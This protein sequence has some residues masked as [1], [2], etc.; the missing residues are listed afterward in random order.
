[1][2]KTHG[3]GISLRSLDVNGWIDPEDEEMMNHEVF[4]RQTLLLRDNFKCGVKVLDEEKKMLMIIDSSTTTWNRRVI[5]DSRKF[6]PIFY[7]EYFGIYNLQLSDYAFYFDRQFDN[8]DDMYYV[9][10]K[11]LGQEI[12]A[13]NRFY[14]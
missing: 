1:L 12:F 2:Y 4:K 9:D 11:L 3:A 10:A 14:T 5:T 8:A 7:A 13:E 6:A